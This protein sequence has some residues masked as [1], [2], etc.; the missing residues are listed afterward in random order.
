MLFG[1][2]PM[3]DFLALSDYLQRKQRFEHAVP[4]APENKIG[5]EKEGCRI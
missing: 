4:K 2:G 5:D 3:D 1:R